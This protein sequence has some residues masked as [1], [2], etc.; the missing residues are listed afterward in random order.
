LVLIL[1]KLHSA[2]PAIVNEGNEFLQILNE[3]VQFAQKM[4]VYLFMPSITRESILTRCQVK[5]I[6]GVMSR[7]DG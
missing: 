7:P 5:S 2:D 4:A 1:D 6:T 3:S